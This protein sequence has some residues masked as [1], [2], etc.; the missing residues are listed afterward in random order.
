MGFMSEFAK[1]PV[2]N[3]RTQSFPGQYE[4]REMWNRIFSGTGKEDGAPQMPVRTDFVRGGANPGSGGTWGRSSIAGEAA[5]KRLLQAMRSLAPGGWSD[6]RWEQWKHF[7]GITYIAVHRICTQLSRGEFQ[8]FRK[9]QNH[10]DG[11]IPVDENTDEEGRKLIRLLEKPNN[12]DSFGKLMYRWGQQ[13]WLTGTALT[14]M[15]PNMLRQPYELYCIPTPIAIPQ[16]AINPDYPD[17][18]YRIQP[19]YPYGPF[20][21]YPTPTTA[22]GAPVPA[23]WMLR[24][25]FPHPLLRYEGWSP[26]T[27]LNFHIDGVESI[28]RSRFYKMKK[29]IKPSAVLNMD[30]MESQQPLPEPEVER[31]HAE[32]EAFMGPENHGGI[33]VGTPGARLEEFGITPSEMDYPNSWEQL[34]SFIL[35]GLGI[36][37]P[38]AG[39]IEDSSYATLFATLKQLYELTLSPFC[40]DVGASLTRCLGPFFGEDLIIEVRCKRIDDHDVA[41]AKVGVMTQASLGTVNEARKLLDL[42]VVQ[43]E[44]GKERLG[45]AGAEVRAAAQQEQMAQQQQEQS[46]IP[47]GEGGEEY[48]TL[49]GEE[50]PPVEAPEVAESREGPEELGQGSLGPRMKSMSLYQIAD[51]LGRWSNVHDTDKI[52][53]MADALEENGYPNIGDL[54]RKTE[55]FSHWGKYPMSDNNKEF[56]KYWSERMALIRA[57]NTATFWAARGGKMLM[58]GSLKRHIKGLRRKYNKRMSLNGV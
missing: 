17:G 41:M 21:S 4:G 30:E 58:N 32:Y 19:V 53:V 57:V 49:E 20:S 22:V 42:P 37:K 43:E 27:G 24:F 46:N 44:W 23:Q 1:S 52:L 9:A 40:E 51:V 7:K 18:F 54:R 2:K 55:I 11:K 15:V 39:M 14:W 8:V 16:P 45:Q 26:L 36:T 50:V 25:Q 28:D 12:Q 35:G 48:N 47:M 38:A 34:T 29:S 31:I 33:L 10:P 13:Q 3:L 6:D 56:R 5:T